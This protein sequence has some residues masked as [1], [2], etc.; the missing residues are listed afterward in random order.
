MMRTSHDSSNAQP[1]LA[2]TLAEN[3][4]ARYLNEPILPFTS[5]IC[6]YWQHSPNLK[7]RSLAKK[8]L[9]VPPS[10]VDSERLFSVAG[11]IAD[12]KRNRLQPHILQKLLF[13]KKNLLQFSHKY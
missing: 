4:L 6:Q 12:K 7:L 9:C 11:N 2:Q 8:F 1:E 5:D 10:T 3:E 13:V